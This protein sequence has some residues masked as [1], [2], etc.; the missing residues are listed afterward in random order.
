MLRGHDPGTRRAHPEPRRPSQRVVAPVVHRRSSRKRSIDRRRCRPPALQTCRRSS[1]CPRRDAASGGR[2]AARARSRATDPQP[3]TGRRLPD[4]PPQ[5]PAPARRARADTAASRAGARQ[6]AAPGGRGM[7]PGPAAWASSRR[8][9]HPR[10]IRRPLVE[11]G[12]PVTAPRGG[13][14]SP[15]ARTRCGV[16]WPPRR[17]RPATRSRWSGASRSGLGSDVVRGRYD[18]VDTTADGAIITDYKSSDVRDQGKADE[19]ARESLQLQV[20]A[21][22]WEA[23]TGQLPKQME[24]HFLDSGVV[25]RVAPEPSRLDRARR[26]LAQ[27]ADGIRAGE[28]PGQAGHDRLRL[29]PIS[30]DLPVVGGLTGR[31]YDPPNVLLPERP[32]WRSMHPARPA[33]SRRTPA[34]RPARAASMSPSDRS[35]PGPTMGAP[36]AGT[37]T[38]RHSARRRPGICGRRRVLRS[39]GDHRRRRTPPPAARRRHRGHPVR[40]PGQLPAGCP[41]RAACHPTGDLDRWRLLAGAGRGALPGAGRGRYG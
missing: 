29:L 25:G 39:A 2:H 26:I 9:R 23:E 38:I 31:A 14:L 41:F 3:F 30:R 33:G 28:L 35:I 6:R 7:A 5:V 1:I 12:L 34:M 24:L 22:A 20:Y 16:S 27:A 13:A 4:V 11:R 17:T 18:R 40:R 36:M 19:R 8:S 15:R 10:G 32:R 21:L 37:R